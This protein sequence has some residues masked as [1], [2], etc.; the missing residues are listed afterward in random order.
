MAA[1]PTIAAANPNVTLHMLGDGPLRH[2]VPTADPRITLEFP[3]E[4]HRREQV[5]DLVH[6]STV[7]VTP[8]HPGPD[9]DSESLL[10]VNLEAAASGRPVVSTTH[11]GIP[12][13]VADGV[14]GLLVAPH[15]VEELSAA[16]TK[17]LSDRELAES[18]AAAGPAHAA[19]WDVRACTSRI[20]DLYDELLDAR[21]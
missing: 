10:L 6:R 1:W 9:G 17:V 21:K 15:S 18:L 8:S 12:E 3:D 14:T 13:Y 11:G 16:V 5:R 7:V 19:Q 4:T 20:D 2:L